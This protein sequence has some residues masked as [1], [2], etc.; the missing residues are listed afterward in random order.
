MISLQQ[1]HPWPPLLPSPLLQQATAR[2]FRPSI[3]SFPIC[4]P[5]TQVSAFGIRSVC[6]MESFLVNV[7]EF[8]NPRLLNEYGDLFRAFVPVAI[9][10]VACH[11]LKMQV[12]KEM[13]NA[14]IRSTLQLIGLGFV[15][16]IV[17][18][19]ERILMSALA[20]SVMILIAG[21]TAGERA[22]ELPNSHVVAT[23][24]LGI[25][26]VGTLGLMLLLK[27]FPIR[28]RYIIPTAGYVA[29][30]SMSMVGGTLNRLHHDIHLHRGQVCLN[31]TFSFFSV[32]KYIVVCVCLFDFL[33]EICCPQGNLFA[34]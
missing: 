29:G 4:S 24:S 12:A 2:P 19:G 8:C 20:V 7:K 27:A 10:V 25:G 15:L 11:R 21:H 31:T 3:T 1:L 28:P 17:F 26:T 5:T 32:R 23:L 33:E 16:K 13:Q 6:A 34:R 9:A 14:V 30:S 22:K 18:Q